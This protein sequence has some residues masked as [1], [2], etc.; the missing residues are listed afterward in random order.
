VTLCRAHN[1]GTRG[2]GVDSDHRSVLHNGAAGDDQFT[3][4]PGRG[5][6]EHQHQRIDVLE[7]PVLVD[8]GP[9]EQ[10]K[11]ARRTGTNGATGVL[12]GHGQP[13]VGKGGA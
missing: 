12:V 9:I 5:A 1:L 3:D 4:M 10:Q 8:G 11:V 2:F 6:G 7:Q 13:A